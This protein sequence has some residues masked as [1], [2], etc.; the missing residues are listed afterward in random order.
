MSISVSTLAFTLRKISATQLSPVKLGH[1]QQLV[2]AVLGYKSLAAHQAAVASGDESPQLDAAR[3]IV[4][5]LPLLMERAQ[6][7]ALTDPPQTLLLLV[8][9]TFEHCVPAASVHAS[10]EELGDAVRAY[11]DSTILNH[12]KTAGQMAGT[13]NDGIQEVYVPF[14]FCMADLPAPGEPLELELQGHVSMVVD[15]E[16]PYSGHRINVE[17]QLVLERIGRSA[18]AAPLCNLTRA[19]L[20][21]AWGDDDQDASPKISLAEALANEMGI[22]VAEA[23]ELADVEPQANASS[24][25]LVYGYI[26]DFEDVASPEIARKILKKYRT[27]QVE[28]PA[29]FFDHV[30]VAQ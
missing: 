23:E 21:Y 1:A 5:N 13:N 27:L 19:R 8:R 22:S 12:E 15:T 6:E 18:L 16:R 25:G 14:D 4:L 2:A 3:H 30:S 29:W 28:V 11:I 24:D 9:A 10:E 26:L 17:A 20:D 7:L